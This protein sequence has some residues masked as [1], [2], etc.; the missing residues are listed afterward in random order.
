MDAVE[1]WLEAVEGW[2]EGW[3][4]EWMLARVVA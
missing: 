2:L 3:L 1:G 4:E